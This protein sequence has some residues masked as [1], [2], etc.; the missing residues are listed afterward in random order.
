VSEAAA[1]RGGAPSDINSAAC[2]EPLLSSLVPRL[3]LAFSNFA[4]SGAAQIGNVL[5]QVGVGDISQ[6]L[7]QLSPDLPPGRRIEGVIEFPK[8][9]RR[10]YQNE[11]IEFVLGV[12]L[13]QCPCDLVDEVPFL[14]AV[15]ILARLHSMASRICAFVGSARPFHTELVRVTV[16][17]F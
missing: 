14:G 8:R 9:V 6:V 17:V 13:I 5:C 2:R 11:S 12:C 1:R 15:Q 4:A 3:D 10:S 7:L 16:D